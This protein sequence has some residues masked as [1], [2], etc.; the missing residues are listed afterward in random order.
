ML[1]IILE[2]VGDCSPI[3][4]LAMSWVQAVTGFSKYEREVSPMLILFIKKFVL[5]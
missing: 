2:P 4:K 3:E 5:V 1:S